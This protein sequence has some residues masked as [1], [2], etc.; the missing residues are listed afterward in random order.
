MKI[1]VFVEGP[2]DKQ[3]MEVLLRPLLEE[4]REAGIRIGFFESPTGDKKKTLL[5]KV[6]IKAVNILGNEPDS[7]VVAMPDLYPRNK[8]FPHETVEELV[9]GMHANFR[10]A[11]E[12]KGLEPDERI[13]SRFQVFCFKHDL[14]ALLLVADRPLCAA[15]G[16]E[17]LERNWAL[18]VENQNHDTPPKRIIENLFEECGQRY[19]ETADAPLIL[20]DCSYS[21]IAES[22]P[23]GF[24]RFVSFLEKTTA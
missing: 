7:M 8:G 2:S 5:N 24:G 21:E 1:I 23:Q 14:E 11:L 4:K 22:C 20:R 18:D 16:T 3:A 6:P 19:H 10:E 15:L 17:R 13:R 12:K 9:D